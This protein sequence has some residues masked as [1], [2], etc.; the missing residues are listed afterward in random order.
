MLIT[1][2]VHSAEGRKLREALDRSS[3][4]ATVKLRERRGHTFGLDGCLYVANAFHEF[5]EILRF[6][7]DLD[8]RGKHPS[9]LAVGGD[10]SF[11]VASR[12]TRQVLRYRISDGRAD[13]HPF[14]DDLENEPEF[15]EPVRRR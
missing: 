5:S 8:A 11:Y 13:R 6:H 9:G 7:G 4:P 2:H 12:G 10:G 14:I 15:I 1:I 3:L